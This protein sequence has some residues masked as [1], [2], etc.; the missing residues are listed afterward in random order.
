[1]KSKTVWILLLALFVLYVPVVFLLDAIYDP[2]DGGPPP[3]AGIR[4]RIPNEIGWDHEKGFAV[5]IGDL[6]GFFENAENWP[7]IEVWEG[8]R[9][10][11]RQNFRYERG[12]GRGAWI[13][14]SPSDGTDPLTNGR[15]YW[16]VNPK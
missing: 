3:S 11:P 2:N 6:A 12:T 1:M 16:V 13:Y 9:R 8:D 14:W 5:R 7:N 10:L 15:A 4:F